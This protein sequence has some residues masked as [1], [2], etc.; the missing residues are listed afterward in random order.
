[1][2]RQGDQDRASRIDAELRAAGITPGDPSLYPSTAD[3]LHAPA[4]GSDGH[5]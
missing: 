3:D 5:R 4:D 2:R 1:V